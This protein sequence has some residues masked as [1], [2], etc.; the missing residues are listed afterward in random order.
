MTIQLTTDSG[1]DVPKHLQEAW[2]IKVV[3]LFVRFGEEQYKSEDITTKDF[4]ERVSTGKVFP[5]SLRLLHKTIMILLKR[6]IRRS[7]SFI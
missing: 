4:L 7:Q 2:D 3:S 1:A 5:Q 6:L